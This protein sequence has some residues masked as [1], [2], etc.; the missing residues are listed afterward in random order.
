[1]VSYGIGRRPGS[2]GAV[3]SQKSLHKRQ[4]LHP[5]YWNSKLLRDERRFFGVARKHACDKLAFCH[6]CASRCDG[7]RQCLHRV[8]RQP[9]Q[10]ASSRAAHQTDPAQPSETDIEH[11]VSPKVYARVEPFLVRREPEFS[12][13]K[14]N[15]P[16]ESRNLLRSRLDTRPATDTISVTEGNGLD[17]SV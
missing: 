17:L 15:D 7:S 6:R 8:L 14:P 9:F 2:S 10:P 12:S 11:L 5:V 4:T 16:S 3:R 1:M 13:W